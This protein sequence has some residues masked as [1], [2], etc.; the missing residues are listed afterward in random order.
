MMS[1]NIT[2]H[3][4]INANAS[5]SAKQQAIVVA[6]LAALETDQLDLPVLP[7]MA[8]KVR[9]LLDDPDSSTGQFVRLLST[10]LAISL[11]FIKAANSAAFSTGHP[12]GNVHDAISRLGYRMLYSMVMNITLTKL[13]QARSSL[14][15]QKLKELWER[16]RRVAANSYVLAQKTK[17][18]KPEDAMLAGLVHEIGALPLYLYADRCYPGIAPESLEIL[19]STFSA[20][21]GLRLLQSWNFPDELVDVVAD[22]MDLRPMDQAGIADY[23][24][25]VTMANLQM[26]GTTKNIEWKNAFAAG[27]LGC[28][29]DDCKNIIASHAE[30][31]AAVSGMLGI[32]LAQAT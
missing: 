10:D 29:P 14:I 25:V 3:L 32:G 26:Q 9:N 20:P 16:S 28:S 31:F 23:V 4:D 17:H 27:R 21:V 12:V 11:Y 24:D 7:D 30:Q 8:I 22:Q 2:E 19:I 6:V 13:F 5:L 1:K 18:L 15:D